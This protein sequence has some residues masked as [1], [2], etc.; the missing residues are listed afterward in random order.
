MPV[1]TLGCALVA[2]GAPSIFGG[3]GFLGAYIAGMVV[4]N[5]P[6]PERFH[7]VRV[8]DSL[9]WLAQ[10]SMFLMLGLL[11]NPSELPHVAW[12]GLLLALF[13]ALV[14]R[15]VTV[16]ACLLP[17]RFSWREKLFIAW[18]GLRGAVPIILATVPVLRSGGQAAHIA[19]ALD[20]FDLV[21][22]VVVVSALVPGATVQHVA[23]WLRLD[24]EAVDDSRPQPVDV[25]ETPS[26]QEQPV[27]AD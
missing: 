22:F 13:L 8:H 19:E 18:V 16:F 11:V 23:R 17:F 1:L 4:G 27:L 24:A 9:S 3:S 12:T 15:P 5:S 21:F 25:A 10:V 6:V 7:L 14:A 20:V 26:A 2:F